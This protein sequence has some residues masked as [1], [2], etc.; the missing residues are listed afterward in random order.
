M[1][2]KSMMYDHAAYIARSS[3]TLG[4]TVAGTGGATS[5]WL[6]FTS[7]HI[8]S[9]GAT[10]ITAGTSTYTAWN[11]T[12]TVTTTGTGDQ[13]SGIKISGT[14][15]STY[16]PYALSAIVGGYSRIQ[17]SGTGIGSSTADG[18]VAMVAGD[19]FYAVRGTDTTGLQLL[20]IEYGV[21]PNALVSA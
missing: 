17:I 1:S 5:K 3:D 10:T 7:S 12:A 2:Q 21:D 14:T 15:T 20:T 8:F 19:Q 16:G 18:G 9:I 6:A 13:I 4:L 11:G